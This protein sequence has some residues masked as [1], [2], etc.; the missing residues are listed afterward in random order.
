MCISLQPISGSGKGSASIGDILDD[1]LRQR[2]GED[3]YERIDGVGIVPSKKQ[4]AL[5]NFNNKDMGRFVFLLEYRACLPSIKLSS[6]DTVIIFN[7][8][9]NPANDLRALNK[10]AIDSQSEKIMIFRLYTSST[11]EEKILR[12]AEHNV[13]IDSKLQNI[14]RS[15]SDA[16]LMWGVTYLFNKLDEFHN[17]SGV[18]T[19][20]EE[21]LLDELL[22]EFI[23]LITHVRMNKDATKLMITRAQ[24][25]GEIYGKNHTVPNKTGGEQPHT[26]WRKLLVGRDPCWKYLAISNPRQ[27][28]SKRP[29]Y[30]EQSPEKITNDDVARKRKKTTNNITESVASKPAEEGEVVGMYLKFLKF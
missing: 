14:S 13:T 11:L 22:E 26:F 3:S 19:C 10:I 27:R 5:N 20:S 24:P 23:N 17:A 18:N 29:Q 28:K 16:L 1:F 9:W 15:T 6:V 30:F 12:L 7:S 25:V 8:E 2:F 21:C 4:A